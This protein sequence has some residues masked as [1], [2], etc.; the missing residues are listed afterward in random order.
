MSSVKKYIPKLGEG[1]YTIPEASQILG[2]KQDKLRAWVNKY[3]SKL[4]LDEK[5]NPTVEYTTKIN[6]YKI[7]KFEV[8]IEIYIV[9]KLRNVGIS[10]RKIHQARKE[11]KEKY[12]KELNY[13]FSNSKVINNLHIE[14]NHLCLD[15]KGSTHELCEFGQ[16]VP[17]EIIKHLSDKIQF[18]AK[19][20]MPTEFV[21]NENYPSIIIDPKIK[22]GS[23]I[24]KG[25]R[26][27]PEIIY[28]F[29]KNDNDLEFLKEEYKLDSKQ[30]D[31][32]IGYYESK[33]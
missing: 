32:V 21:P 30:I 13:P 3:W 14:K 1:I 29:Y 16:I 15:Y 7:F 33:S 24:I 5:F 17:T 22:L 28:S 20:G 11:I 31:D 10:F 26:L 23:L 18:D 6:D 2:I 19:S 9:N 4:Y 8:L 25:T 27:N 12:F